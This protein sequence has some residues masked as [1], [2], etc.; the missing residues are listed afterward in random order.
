MKTKKLSGWIPLLIPL[1]LYVTVYI[2][3]SYALQNSFQGLT[4]HHDGRTTAV[5]D[6]PPPLRQSAWSRR[7]CGTMA[8]F[9]TALI[10]RTSNAADAIRI[11]LNNMTTTTTTPFTT[12]T[13][14]A[15][16]ALRRSAAHL[17]G[18]GPTD[19]FYPLNWQGT[20]TLRRED[21]VMNTS[22][23]VV[24]Y[25]VRFIPCVENDAVVADRA[26]NE[27]QYWNAKGDSG[28]GGGVV[29]SI[30]WTE[31]NPNDL[32]V[33][34]T[35]GM[36]QN[37]KIT[38]RATERTET[39]VSSSEFQRILEDQSSS[40]STSSS[41]MVLVPPQLSSRRTLTKWK[42]INDHE[43]EGIEIVYDMNVER[44]ADLN[45]LRNGT[46]PQLLS[47]SRLKLSR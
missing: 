2:T 1:L 10:C 12:T 7:D 18:Y 46:P 38:K 40:S 37:V 44:D 28:G 39:T 21:V 33:V 31:T 13:T 19:V 41:S 15:G 16:E 11:P 45:L 22:E 34:F 9:H 32:N 24:T 5:D 42:M 30:Q 47:K 20:W 25:P 43:M 29:Q 4:G 35:N 36:R 23:S 27:R 26:F 8:F 3:F 6:P 17:P 14:S